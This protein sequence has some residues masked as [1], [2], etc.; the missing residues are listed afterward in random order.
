MSQV[1]NDKSIKQLMAELDEIMS[2]FGSGELDIDEAVAKF[3]QASKLASE[4]KR[5]L[6]EVENK[7]T[8]IELRLSE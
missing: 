6:A 8:E 5:K 2:W 4:I 1:K 7:I 3:D